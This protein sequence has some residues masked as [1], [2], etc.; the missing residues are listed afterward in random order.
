MKDGQL[1][2]EAKPGHG[3]G[4]VV[5]VQPGVAEV[6]RLRRTQSTGLEAADGS[7]RTTR[8]ERQAQRRLV[9]RVVFDAAQ[10]VEQQDHTEGGHAGTHRHRLGGRDTA[11]R[12]ATLRVI[13]RHVV[14]AGLRPVEVGREARLFQLPR[15]GGHLYAFGEAN[16]RA[17]SEM[18]IGQ[19]GKNSFTGSVA[20]PPT[21]I[22]GSYGPAA[23]PLNP[24]NGELWTRGGPIT[25]VFPTFSV[26]ATDPLLKKCHLLRGIGG[27]TAR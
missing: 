8:N 27:G 21:S 2:L 6:T 23:V 22:L 15:L 11:P 16:P 5:T 17:P 14:A 9:R 10:G 26:T 13:R 19:G 4:C 24:S 1:S 3:A 7:L 25:R 12:P 18:E 20:V